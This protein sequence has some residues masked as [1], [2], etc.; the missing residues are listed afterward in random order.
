MTSFRIAAT[1]LVLSA[2]M[3]GAAHAQPAAPPA[4]TDWSNAQVVEVDLDSYSF[5]PKSLHLKAGTPYRLHF[6]NKASKGHNFD[7]PEF[8]AALVVS[9]ADQAKVAD[10]KIELDGGAS[11]DIQV[12]PSVPGTYPVKCSH[13][14]H[15]TLG[16]S[17]EAVIE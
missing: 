10:G 7:A 16:M 3:F 13:F 11:A 15:S 6:V 17:G 4:S 14:M 8:F 2:L 5:T 12:V 1:G 9:P